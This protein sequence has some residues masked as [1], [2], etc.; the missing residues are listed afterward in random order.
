MWRGQGKEAGDKAPQERRAE[1]NNERGADS[2]THSLCERWRETKAERSRDLQRFKDT[3]PCLTS[4]L[5][6]TDTHLVD[7]GTHT[8]SVRDRGCGLGLAWQ[9]LSSLTVS[10]SP[11]R[12][13]STNPQKKLFLAHL[14]STSPQPEQERKGAAE[15]RREGTFASPE[16]PQ[17][18]PGNNFRSSSLAQQPWQRVP[19]LKSGEGLGSG[20]SMAQCSPWERC[21]GREPSEKVW[22]RPVL[23]CLLGLGSHR[24]PRV[25]EARKWGSVASLPNLDLVPPGYFESWSSLAF[26]RIWQTSVMG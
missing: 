20:R 23:Q 14:P 4:I 12:S 10:L 1:E 22:S 11:W 9:H 8:H 13:L 21:R 24:L 15:Q 16:R 18:A 7:E 6:D 26:C 5:T 3:L 17:P 2:I 25:P 19:G